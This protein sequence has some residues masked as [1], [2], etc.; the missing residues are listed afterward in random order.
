MN[1]DCGEIPKLHVEEEVS[2]YAITDVHS[3]IPQNMEWVKELVKRRKERKEKETSILLVAGDVA[4][5][6]ECIGKTLSLFKEVID[7]YIL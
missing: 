6:A 7:I 4:E 1:F 5:T 2:V 3:S